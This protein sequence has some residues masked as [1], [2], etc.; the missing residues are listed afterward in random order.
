MISS[1]FASPL[2]AVAPGLLLL[3]ALVAAGCKNEPTAAPRAGAAGPPGGRPGGPPSVPVKVAEV[4]QK[5][6]APEV[7]FVA[8]VQPSVSTTVGAELA[9]QVTEVPVREGDRVVADRT[10][11]ARLDTGPRTIALRE[12]E[13]QVARARE[14]LEKLRRG[15]R[16]EEIAQRE[17]EL[18]GQKAVLDRTEADRRRANELERDGFISRAERDRAES[19]YLAALARHRQ[20]AEAHRMARAGP[21]AEEIAQAEADLAR[22]RARSDM[23]RDEIRR[24]VVRAPVTGYLVKKH[25][26]AGA[27]VQ[28]G[29]RIADLVVLDPVYVTGPVGEREIRLVKEGQAAALALDAYPNQ[30]FA[31][32]VTAVIPDADPTNRT[33][34]VRV[35]VR[36]PDGLLKPGMFARVSLRAGKERSGLF[37]PRA[38][39]VRRGDE[40]LV[41]VVD[42]QQAKA[43]RV[44]TAT[45][46]D[47]LVEVQ[48]DG[49]RAGVRVVT[50]G[51]ELLQPGAKVEVSP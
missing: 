4:V 41:Y 18:A 2:R 47:G 8:T 31:G 35:T 24:S 48:G 45:E 7:A 28:A 16:A 22:A 9:G 29:G 10:V 14:E 27:W 12:A 44:Q 40:A 42:E 21:R 39:L 30:A 26:E 51:N 23:I 49:L 11:L 32:T 5:T 20:L 15:N 25:V 19:D 1:P 37:V 36:N 6:V 46:R 34:P 13:A 3:L 50:L 38:A 43:V 17:A 33:F